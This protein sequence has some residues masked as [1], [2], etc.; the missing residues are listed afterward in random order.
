MPQ[1]GTWIPIR[2]ELGVAAF[3]VNAWTGDEG[4]DVIPAHDEVPTGHEELYVV[5]SGSATF[6]VGDETVDGPAGTIIFVRD[7]AVRRGAVAQE[8][9]TV[10]LT[11]GAKA[12]AVYAPGAW[13]VNAE[14]F[15]L[16]EAGEFAEA[17]RRLE[18]ELAKSPEAGDLLYNLACAESRLGETDAALEHLGLAVEREP[19]YAEYATDDEDFA[20]LRDDPRF[21]SAV[22]GQA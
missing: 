21:A 19:R 17:K 7:P 6:T 22:A 13:E 14:I 2:R 9:G 12:G 16:F 15:P 18:A 4:A 5:T 11:V 20:P 3:G 8:A 10:V 1:R